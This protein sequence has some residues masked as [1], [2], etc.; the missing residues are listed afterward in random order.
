MFYVKSI[1]LLSHMV[2]NLTIEWNPRGKVNQIERNIIVSSNLR[3][4]LK[5]GFGLVLVMSNIY[6]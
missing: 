2:F 6:Y 1:F 5:V 4:F 3:Y